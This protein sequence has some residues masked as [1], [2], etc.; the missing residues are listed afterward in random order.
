MPCAPIVAALALA[1]L[2]A[3]ALLA[4]ESRLRKALQELL[5]RVLFL[6]RNHASNVSDRDID[7]ELRD[8]L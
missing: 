4:R 7:R 6:W 1:L 2:I 3:V 5:R 8:R